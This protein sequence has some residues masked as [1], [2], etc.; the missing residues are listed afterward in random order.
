MIK[1]EDEI[2]TR[3]YE[4]LI[5]LSQ[6]KDLRYLNDAIR[7]CGIEP[8]PAYQ[9]YVDMMETVAWGGKL[10]LYGVGQNAKKYYELE[11]SEKVRWDTYMFHSLEILA[12][13]QLVIEN[14]KILKCYI[15][16]FLNIHGK[17]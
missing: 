15:L 6:T 8:D 11:R 3:L 16:K 2:S 10:V 17:R 4:K 12:G 5:N 9:Q 14:L 13:M 7:L 1:F